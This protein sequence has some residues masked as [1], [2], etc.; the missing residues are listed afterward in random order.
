MTEPEQ[1]PVSN[2]DVVTIPITLTVNAWN[3]LIN[4][5]FDAPYKVSAALIAQ[6]TNHQAAQQQAAAQAQAA[7]QAQVN[8]ED[9]RPDA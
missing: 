2:P 4:Y 1:V 5:L 8:G 3:L 6:V 9:A 7:Q